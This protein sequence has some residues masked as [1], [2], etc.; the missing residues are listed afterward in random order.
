M[1]DKQFDPMQYRGKDTVYTAIPGS[2]GIATI[3]DWNKQKRRYTKRIAGNQYYAYKK[4]EG[5]QVSECFETFK[6][7]K[8]W[9]ET[10]HF[11]L[12]GSELKPVIFQQAKERYDQAQQ[13][14]QVLIRVKRASARDRNRLRELDQNIKELEKALE[15]NPWNEAAREG[16]DRMGPS[17][18]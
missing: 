1:S 16:L 3:W 2:Q 10:C 13:G 7:A 4:V 12:D 15:Y 14:M 18:G 5:K 9:R 8:A 6:E 11:A 17:W